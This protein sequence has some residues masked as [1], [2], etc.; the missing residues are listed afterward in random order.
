MMMM[1]LITIN[2]IPNC[3]WPGE[4]VDDIRLSK[5][6]MMIMMI[7]HHDKCLLVR[8]KVMRRLRLR[9]WLKTFPTASPFHHLQYHWCLISFVFPPFPLSRFSLPYLYPRENRSSLTI[10]LVLDSLSSSLR[11]Q[12]F[13]SHSSFSSSFSL[14]LS[15]NRN[16]QFKCRVPIY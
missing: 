2:L 16:W 7:V 4:E 1:M 15:D 14:F 6:M 8:V 9:H 12:V 11:Q 3:A 10:S 13:L 5:L